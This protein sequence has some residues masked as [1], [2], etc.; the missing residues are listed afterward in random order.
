MDEI[1]A[2]TSEEDEAFEHEMSAIHQAALGG[3]M[4]PR[5]DFLCRYERAGKE[6]RTKRMLEN[7]APSKQLTCKT[8]YYDE[9]STCKT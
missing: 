8:G 6:A 7:T 2:A 1:N 5:N 4:Q 3:N 9:W